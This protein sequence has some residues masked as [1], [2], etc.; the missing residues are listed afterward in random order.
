MMF[1]EYLDRKCLTK[2]EVVFLVEIIADW[3]SEGFTS[4]QS[5]IQDAMRLKDKL[6]SL[7]TRE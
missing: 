3:I 5:E 4:N 7:F 2:E 6:E 1:E